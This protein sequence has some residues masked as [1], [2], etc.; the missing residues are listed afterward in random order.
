MNRQLPSAPRDHLVGVVAEVA[1]ERALRIA[2]HVEEVAR[3]GGVVA[4]DLD[5]R[6]DHHVLVIVVGRVADGVE[7]LG[8]LVVPRR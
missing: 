6:L 1:D 3:D 5:D 4:V 2:L 7:V 8:D